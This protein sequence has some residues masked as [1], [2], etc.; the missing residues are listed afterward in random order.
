MI[1]RACEIAMLSNVGWNTTKLVKPCVPQ[2]VLFKGICQHISLIGIQIPKE[3]GLPKYDFN[4]HKNC[5]EE[6]SAKI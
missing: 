6:G 5:K 1:E 4:G 2:H 3:K